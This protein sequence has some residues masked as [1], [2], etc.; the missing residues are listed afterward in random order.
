[1]GFDYD[2]MLAD[3]RRSV[4]KAD[5]HFYLTAALLNLA[6]G[7]LLTT[8]GNFLSLNLPSIASCQQNTPYCLMLHLE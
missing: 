8:T 6:V 3:E 5:V 4:S 1:L 7:L 2:I